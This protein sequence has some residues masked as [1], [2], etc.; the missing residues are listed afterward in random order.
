M[1]RNRVW[2]FSEMFYKFILLK[3]VL[4]YF[5]MDLQLYGAVTGKGG[6]Q[7][8]LQKNSLC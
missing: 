2:I 7:E 4:H 5:K 6:Q 1:E 3:P 8:S